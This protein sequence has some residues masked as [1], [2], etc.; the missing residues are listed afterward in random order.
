LLMLLAVM[1]V[2]LKAYA[3]PTINLTNSVVEVCSGITAGNIAYSGTTGSPIDYSIDFDAIAE[4][5]GFVDVTNAALALPPS[6]IVI[7]IP[8]GA[9]PAN[10]SGSLT[11]RDAGL[12]VSAALP[13]TVT[14]HA[15]PVITT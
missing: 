7:T 9:T 1:F 6:Q 14:I 2:S 15:N 11:V 4:A 5:Q 10:Y 3:Q 13:I 8:P 12:V